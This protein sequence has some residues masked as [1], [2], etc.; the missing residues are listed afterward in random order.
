MNRL[1]QITIALQTAGI[2]IFLIWLVMRPTGADPSLPFLELQA[3]TERY[4]P[5]KAVGALGP[6]IFSKASALCRREAC[7]QARYGGNRGRWLTVT[8]A[9]QRDP[10]QTYQHPPCGRTAISRELRRVV[11]LIGRCEVKGSL[12]RT[13]DVRLRVQCDGVQDFVT[14]ERNGRNG[15]SLVG[16]E[17]YPGFLP[18]LHAA[19]VNRP[20]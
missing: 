12:K 18:R 11:A 16:D 14:V 15:W 10:C 19:T 7:I 8:A 5:G 4:G 13:S 9:K 6:N 20:R 3:F 2:L 1:I 17:R